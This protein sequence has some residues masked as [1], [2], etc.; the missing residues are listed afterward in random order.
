MKVA[1]NVANPLGGTK[2]ELGQLLQTW[3]GPNAGLP[4]TDFKVHFSTQH[5]PWL[6][7]PIVAT[8]GIVSNFPLPSCAAGSRGE[9]ARVR[10]F[11]IDSVDSAPETPIQLE[12]N[13]KE[14]AKYKTHVPVYDLVAAAGDWGDE[15]VPD[16]IGWLEVSD[17]KL[18][19]GM[20][21]AQVVGRSMEPKIPSGSCLQTMMPR[22][23]CFDV[24][25]LLTRTCLLWRAPHVDAKRGAWV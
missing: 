5:G 15:G 20:F 7:H 12:I 3:F 24:S 22:E 9:R 14:S 4:G 13:V 1:C 19:P 18:T 11:P 21:A 10:G 23:G 25:P 8:Q 17:R 2:N 16:K 6:A